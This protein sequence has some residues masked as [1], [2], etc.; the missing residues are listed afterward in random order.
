MAIEYY[1]R[2]R[3]RGAVSQLARAVSNRRVRRRAYDTATWCRAQNGRKTSRNPDANPDA[4]CMLIAGLSRLKRW[5]SVR[6]EWR[7][8]KASAKQH[9][10]GAGLRRRVVLHR[11][12]FE[13][14]F[15]RW[16]RF[17]DGRNLLIR[18]FRTANDAYNAAVWEPPSL[19]RLV[20][21]VVGAGSTEVWWADECDVQGERYGPG[22]Q[23]ADGAALAADAPVSASAGP[24]G[25]GIGFSASSMLNALTALEIVPPPPLFLHRGLSTFQVMYRVTVAWRCAAAIRRD[26]RAALAAAAAATSWS[27]I[28]LLHRT[29]LGWK[30][31]HILAGRLR[32]L[33]THTL[34]RR[35]HRLLR[36]WR[37]HAAFMRSRTGII[38]VASERRGLRDALFHWQLAAASSAWIKRDSLS[39]WRDMA[40]NSAARKKSAS[41]RGTISHPCHRHWR[42]SLPTSRRSRLTNIATS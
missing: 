7:L 20:E 35:V 10:F 18:V 17:H 27:C 37:K 9:F 1:D 2:R 13:S 6:Q 21:T 42:A 5:A 26:H 3:V 39:H 25:V 24:S 15:L 14:V 4:L 29:W 23:A 19:Q 40:A 12:L 22:G 38:R 8:R 41:V 34:S 16:Q 33:T 31:F 11:A 30:R 32:R 28:T 36:G